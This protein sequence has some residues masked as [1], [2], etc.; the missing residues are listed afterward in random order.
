MNNNIKLVGKGLKPSPSDF[1]DYVLSSH[2][3]QVKRYPKEKPCPFDLK[4]NNQWFSP[5]CV[6]HSCSTIKEGSER[7]ERV[8]KEFDGEWIYLEAKKID[9]IP[10]FSGTYL[11]T[12]L[13]VLKDVGAKPLEGDE[14]PAKYKIK[15]YARVDDISFEG[16]KKALSVYHFLIAGFNGSNEGWRKE[17]IRPPKEGENLFGHAVAL[18]GYDE[19]HIIGQNSWGDFHWVHG[20]S[21]GFFKTTKDYL[22]FEAWAVL[23]DAPNEIKTL[24]DKLLG[25]VASE[26]VG[27]KKGQLVTLYRLRMRT[28]PR[29]S[30]IIETLPKGT[31]IKTDGERYLA[32]G[33]WWIPVFA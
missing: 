21:G 17:V 18:V 32:D 23:L 31:V 12:G 20:N 15:S 9:G 33:Y 5:S 13:K 3:P 10:D 8:H 28:E 29:F 11:R 27:I 22:P 24:Q 19:N 14:D 25:Y 26:F 30:N 6:G 4:I 16:L 7:L 1:R 2:I